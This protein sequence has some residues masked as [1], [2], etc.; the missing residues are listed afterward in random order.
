VGWAVLLQ[1]AEMVVVAV[2]VT[3]DVA[4]AVTVTGGGAVAEAVTVVVAPG[5][6]G[7]GVHQKVLVRLQRHPR[8]HSGLVKVV[9]VEQG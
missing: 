9:A 2:S 4:V 8:S 6:Q 1:V 7:C 5:V 3:V